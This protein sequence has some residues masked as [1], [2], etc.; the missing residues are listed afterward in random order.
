M[1]NELILFNLIYT[2]MFQL[3]TH[4][5]LH[6]PTETYQIFPNIYASPKRHYVF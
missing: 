4:T 6:T 2:K 3:H 5:H 1:R